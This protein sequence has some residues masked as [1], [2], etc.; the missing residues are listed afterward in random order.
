MNDGILLP[1]IDG[2]DPLHF[3]CTLGIMTALDARLDAGQTGCAP[4]VAW[5]NMGKWRPVFLGFE[6]FSEIATFLLQDRE[7][8][9]DK[10]LDFGYLKQEKKGIKTF[11]GLSPPVAVLRGWLQ[12]DSA[13]SQG[14]AYGACLMAE[15]ATENIKDEKIVSRE[16]ILEN[17]VP[18][19]EKAP[20]NQAAM[21]TFFDF[22]SRNTQFLDQISIIKECFDLDEISNEL[23]HGNFSE[24]A[25]RAMGW[26]STADAPGALFGDKPKRSKPVIE[27]LAFRGLTLLP[28]FGSGRT[29]QTTACS[30]RRKNGLFVWPIWEQ[31]VSLS[32]AAIYS[33]MSYRNLG[34]LNPVERKELGISSVF[35][36]KMAKA[37]DGYSGVFMPSSSI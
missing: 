15:T 27:W 36:S 20:I 37:A 4:R 26:D 34:N 12:K 22:T 24:D 2:S 31:P 35:A 9:E 8:F 14:S 29:L 3:L 18:L 23:L 21:P 19:D 32:R 33:L 11:K 17:N 7:S 6:Q 28:T 30:G 25:K 5:K 13:G 1:G 10:I 16:I